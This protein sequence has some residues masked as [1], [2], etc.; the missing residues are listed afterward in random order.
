MENISEIDELE[1]NVSEIFYSIQ[2]EGTRSGLP[3]VF[4]R[5]QGCNLRC[6]WCDTSYALDLREKANIM[7]G[8]QI[9][10]EIKK[11]SCRFVEFTGGE[12][13]QQENAIPLMKHLCD[14]GYTVA[15]ETN[16]SVDLSPLDERIVKILDIKCP[17]SKMSKFNRFGNIEFV[18]PRDEVKFVIGTREDF[19]WA[20]SVVSEYR[21]AEKGCEILFSPVFGDMENLKLAEWILEAGLP[22]RLQ[23]QIHKYIWAPDARGV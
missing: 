4:V 9:L 20:K 15:I 2:G 14:L 10:E 21:L 23:L 17:S 18:T 1:Y 22:V 3:C 5:L 8:A 7:T 19:D 6:S 12:P 16:G 13:L 11:H